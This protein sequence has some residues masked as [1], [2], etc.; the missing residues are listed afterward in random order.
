[1]LRH[2]S[3]SA[4]ALLTMVVVTTALSAQ[5]T[6]IGF[7]E[8]WALSPDRQKALATLIPGTSD[9]YYYP[10]SNATAAASR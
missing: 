3:S 2:S 4:A 6:P 8:T 7:E 5:G 10:G 1:M 9:W